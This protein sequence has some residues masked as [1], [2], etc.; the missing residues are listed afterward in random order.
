VDA[1][2]IARLAELGVNIVS[3]GALTHAA[4]FVDLSMTV[5]HP[6]HD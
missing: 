1:G 6:G 2:R 5:A 4:R 3:M